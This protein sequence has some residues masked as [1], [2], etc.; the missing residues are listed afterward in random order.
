MAQSDATLRVLRPG[1]YSDPP[2]FPN[3]LS[4]CKGCESEAESKEKL[5]VRDLMTITSPYVHSRIDSDTFTMG[6]L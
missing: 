2:F 4:E 6:T 5:G 1:S 3:L